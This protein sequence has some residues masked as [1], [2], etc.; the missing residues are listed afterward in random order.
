MRSNRVSSEAGIFDY[1]SVRKPDLPSCARRERGI[2][3]NDY[4]R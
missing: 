2:M 1:R 3:R 4:N